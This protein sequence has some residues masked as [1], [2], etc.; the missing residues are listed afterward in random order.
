M[1]GKEKVSQEDQ[2]TQIINQAHMAQ[3]ESDLYS[4]PILLLET[5]K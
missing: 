2:T 5:I 3:D 4:Q 1:L